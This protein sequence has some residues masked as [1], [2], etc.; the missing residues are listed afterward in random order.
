M[1]SADAAEPEQREPRRLEHRGD[2]PRQPRPD[3]PPRE[4]REPREPREQREP[5][6]P[7][8]P[9]G[10]GRAPFQDR[11]GGDRQG[12]FQQGQPR[13]QGERGEDRPQGGQRFERQGDS[14]R[15]RPA[16]Q[17]PAEPRF[18][19]QRGP[20]P[21]RGPERGYERGL[22]IGPPPLSEAELNGPPAD[23]VYPY[24]QQRNA[25]RMEAQETP[26]LPAD[27]RMEAAAK[28][29]AEAYMAWKAQ[30]GE[31]NM[32]ALS[33]ALHEMRKVM[34]RMEIEMSSTRKEEQRPIPIPGYRHNQPPPQQ[35]RG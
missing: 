31:A 33:D 15:D 30:S 22:E 24:R 32:L 23:V 20:R 27:Q 1:P 26:T 29:C 2:G 7:R 35:P 9:Q 28:S 12:R 13:P 18:A 6:E 8:Q 10:E 16:D 17:R 11:R 34:A 19:D 21:D 4:A 14:R 5:R 3:M 25:A